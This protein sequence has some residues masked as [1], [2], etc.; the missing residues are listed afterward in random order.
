MV[1]HEDL[2]MKFPF[3]ADSDMTFHFAERQSNFVKGLTNNNPDSQ[4]YR[5]M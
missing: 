2:I 1:Y 4:H 5:Y 3:E